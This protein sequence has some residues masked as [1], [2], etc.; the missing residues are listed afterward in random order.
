V[1]GSDDPEAAR[2]FAYKILRQYPA[3]GL[4]AWDNRGETWHGVTIGNFA[5]RAQAKTARADL[6]LSKWKHPGWPRSFEEIRRT[7]VSP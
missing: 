3:V 5:S 2:E 6:P 4:F 1:F 7:L